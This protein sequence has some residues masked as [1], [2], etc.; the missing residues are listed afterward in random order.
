MNPK[1]ATADADGYLRKE[2][3]RPEPKNWILWVFLRCRW[4]RIGRVGFPVRNGRLGAAWTL[5]G[6]SGICSWVSFAWV[7]HGGHGGEVADLGSWEIDK[8]EG[9]WD[10][11]QDEFIT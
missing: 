5:S 2:E 8:E 11:E 9:E 3:E 10:W 4:W 1:G 7:W 6:E